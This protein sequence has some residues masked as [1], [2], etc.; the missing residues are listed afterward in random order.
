MSKA[1]GYDGDRNLRAIMEEHCAA[2]KVFDVMTVHDMKSV[3]IS[4]TPN[5]ELAK[6]PAI[7]MRLARDYGLGAIV[8][9]IGNSFPIAYF[10]AAKSFFQIRA[11]TIQNADEQSLARYTIPSIKLLRILKSMQLEHKR[12]EIFYDSAMH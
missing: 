7:V 12:R 6:I 11:V 4:F 3:W 8:F 2:I 9:H 5:T 10:A 1:G